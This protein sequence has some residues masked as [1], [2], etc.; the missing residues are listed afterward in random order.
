MTAS[1]LI[2]SPPTAPAVRPLAA[3]PPRARHV[4]WG[5]PYSGRLDE[6]ILLPGQPIACRLRL[7]EPLGEPR[8]DRSLV[9]V[10]GWIGPAEMVDDLEPLAPMDAFMEPIVSRLRGSLSRLRPCNRDLAS[11]GILEYVRSSGDPSGPIR[12]IFLGNE[13]LGIPPSFAV[14]EP[15][16]VAVLEHVLGESI[17]GEPI[18][19]EPVSGDEGRAR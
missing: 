1:T 4:D 7:F 15:D 12:Q 5:P 6:T 17:L 9:I 14:L 3:L 16:A 10:L 8:S 18:P 11:A 13:S 2:A 19:G